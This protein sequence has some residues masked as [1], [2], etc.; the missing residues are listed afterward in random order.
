MVPDKYHK[1]Q[2][3][4]TGDVTIKP[5]I[6]LCYAS[7]HKLCKATGS[8]TGWEPSNAAL[9]NFQVHCLSLMF[10]IW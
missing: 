7:L 8:V 10:K 1:A 9:T 6:V 5:N 4:R 3:K 2:Y